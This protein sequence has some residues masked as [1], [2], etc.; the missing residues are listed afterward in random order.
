MAKTADFYYP[1]GQ[2]IRDITKQL[3][4]QSERK[5]QLRADYQ[6]A[7]MNRIAMEYKIN[8]PAEKLRRSQA[9][10]LMQPGSTR[11]LVPPGSQWKGEATLHKKFV[12][13]AEQ[14]LGIEGVNIN[15]QWQLIDTKDNKLVTNMPLWR[16]EQVEQDILE[17][18]VINNT[19]AFLLQGQIEDLGMQIKRIQQGIDAGKVP[20]D[21]LKQLRGQKETFEKT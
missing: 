16:R 2:S 9:A 3:Q 20:I 6:N 1:L 5:R 7:Q 10:Y 14:I 8:D 15:D 19:P 21:K 11:S 12:D 18:Q 4:W 17:W 13:N